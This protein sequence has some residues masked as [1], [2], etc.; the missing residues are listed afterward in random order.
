[1]TA[2]QLDED[3]LLDQRHMVAIAVDTFPTVPA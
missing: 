3:G 1:M 2:V